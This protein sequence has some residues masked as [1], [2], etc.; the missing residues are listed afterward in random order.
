MLLVGIR[1]DHQ[2][3]QLHGNFRI[4][5]HIVVDILLKFVLLDLAV[6][7][8]L[9]IYPVADNLRFEIFVHL[10]RLNRSLVHFSDRLLS[11]LERL[12]DHFWGNGWFGDWGCWLDAVQSTHYH[13]LGLLGRL[14]PIS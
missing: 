14:K 9:V 8:Y 2:H 7:E 5:F 1:I 11:D 10:C 12:E 3:L 13:F 6:Q 4:M